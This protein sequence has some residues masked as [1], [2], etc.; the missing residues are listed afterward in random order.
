MNLAPEL[1]RAAQG[2]SPGTT[3]AAVTEGSWRDSC[4]LLVGSFFQRDFVSGWILSRHT[5]TQLKPCLLPSLSSSS[6]SFLPSFSS[7][8]EWISLDSPFFF[9]LKSLSSHLQLLPHNLETGCEG[10]PL[11][12]SLPL[13]KRLTKMH[14]WLLATV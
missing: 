14:C 12:G 13:P 11:L 1:R 6:S 9:F 8:F 2:P 3:L 5:P 7:F 4:W 10:F